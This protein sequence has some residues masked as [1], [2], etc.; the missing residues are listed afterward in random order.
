MAWYCDT[1][2][3]IKLFVQEAESA[4]LRDALSN[5]DL[6]VSQLGLLETIRGAARLKVAIQPERFAAFNLIAITSE[7]VL[8]AASLP[9]AEMRSL[10]AIHLASALQLG[11]ECEGIVTYDRRMQEAARLAG[12]RVEAPAGG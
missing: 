3:L 6:A 7:V 10:D 1:S 4:A 8:R 9:P 5:R 2:A 11:D 12:L